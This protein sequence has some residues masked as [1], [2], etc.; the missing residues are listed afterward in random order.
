MDAHHR[1]PSCTHQREDLPH[2][3]RIEEQIIPDMELGPQSHLL[4]RGMFSRLKAAHQLNRLARRAQNESLKHLTQLR[5]ILQVAESCFLRAFELGYAF[6]REEEV[7][8]ELIC[9]RLVGSNVFVVV[10]I[11]IYSRL[12]KSANNESHG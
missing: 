9:E 7:P 1:K 4:V 5:V 3:I 10:Y 6:A 8:S 11:E 2:A 12:T